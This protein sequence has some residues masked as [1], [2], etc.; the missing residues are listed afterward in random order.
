MVP[1]YQVFVNIFSFFWEVI[2]IEVTNLTRPEDRKMKRIELMHEGVRTLIWTA[3]FLGLV[4]LPYG[5]LRG[6]AL[7]VKHCLGIYC[8]RRRS[9]PLPLPTGHVA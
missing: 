6:V 4:W 1:V 5:L 9:R 2:K 7:F 8:R 3:C